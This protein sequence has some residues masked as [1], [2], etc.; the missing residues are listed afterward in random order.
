M[1][2]IGLG[3][4]GEAGV[5]HYQF[6]Q[7][8][9]PLRPPEIFYKNTT[10]GYGKDGRPLH[11]A[12]INLIPWVIYTLQEA[13]EDMRVGGSIDEM[14]THALMGT[15]KTG[16]KGRQIPDG[17]ICWDGGNVLIEIG[18]CWP[19]KWPDQAWI[20]WSFTGLATVINHNG[21]PMIDEVAEYLEIAAARPEAQQ[22]QPQQEQ[23]A[24]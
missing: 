11:E 1:R 12:M 7:Y 15:L 13:W 8:P 2:V 9:R 17:I 20:H 6:L 21:D 10:M 22:H 23:L 3:Y 4:G 24:A 16:R 5:C 18:Q 14:F 19:D